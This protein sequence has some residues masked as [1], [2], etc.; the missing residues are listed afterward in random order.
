MDELRRFAEGKFE[1]VAEASH[2]RVLLEPDLGQ[3]QGEAVGLVVEDAQIVLLGAGV[4]G[5]IAVPA[6][7]IE[8]DPQGLP[9]LVHGHAAHLRGGVGRGRGGHGL[10]GR[11][12]AVRGGGLGLPLRTVAHQRAKGQK[13]EAG[14]K[15]C[16][17]SHATSTRDMVGK[18]TSSPLYINNRARVPEWRSTSRKMQPFPYVMRVGLSLQRP[19]APGR[20]PR[21]ATY[22]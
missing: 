21:E 8:A 4:P 6:L 22:R 11:G 9:E 12:G 5:I 7:K 13:G 15:G 2:V 20:D 3:I 17:G 19:E 1:V 18:R 16:Q 14:Q 10:G